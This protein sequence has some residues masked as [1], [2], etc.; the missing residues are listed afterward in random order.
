MSKISLSEAGKI[1]TNALFTMISGYDEQDWYFELTIE[2]ALVLIVV[3][4]YAVRWTLD[5]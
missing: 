1:N 4:T 3:T 2:I 5:I